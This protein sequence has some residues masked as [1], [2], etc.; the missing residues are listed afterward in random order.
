MDPKG[1]SVADAPRIQN[2]E[3]YSYFLESVLPKPHALHESLETI[4]E[5]FES[6]RQS[7]SEELSETAWA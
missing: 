5:H 2:V 1:F 3:V 7:M 6:A 4:S